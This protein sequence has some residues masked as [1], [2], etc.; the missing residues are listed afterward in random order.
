MNTKKECKV[1]EIQYSE[2]Y[3]QHGDKLFKIST[4]AIC[5]IFNKTTFSSSDIRVNKIYL[6]QL[7]VYIFKLE[8]LELDGDIV[9]V[10]LYNKDGHF[11]PMGLDLNSLSRKER[12]RA[13]FGGFVMEDI[14]G[15]YPI[16]SEQLL[17]L[18]CD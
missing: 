2:I 14:E 10:Q 3:L 16:N 5:G 1:E 6:I 17:E 15:V 7:C 11:Q 13:I 12:F 8:N 9:R 4:D 18:L